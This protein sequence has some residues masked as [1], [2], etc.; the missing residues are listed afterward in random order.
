MTNLSSLQQSLIN[1]KKVMNKVDG[2]SNNVT[3]PTNSFTSYHP[4]NPNTYTTFTRRYF[5]TIRYKSTT[6]KTTIYKSKPKIW[7]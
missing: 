4:R 3:M 6:T 5:F 7:Y 2:T 1:A